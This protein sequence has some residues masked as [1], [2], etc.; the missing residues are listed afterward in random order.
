M[1]VNDIVKSLKKLPVSNLQQIETG[2]QQK[3]RDPK[4]VKLENDVN[5]QMLN[6]IQASQP[7]VPVETRV[8]G[9]K[10]IDPEAALK[11]LMLLL[12]STDDKS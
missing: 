2:F 10:H 8:D 4:L 12:K 1:N 11:E 5:K 7:S 6:A 3:Q 9:I